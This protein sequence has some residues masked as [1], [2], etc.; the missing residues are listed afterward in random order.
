[1]KGEIMRQAQWQLQTAKAQL[2][3]LIEAALRGNPQR[4]TRRGKDAVMVLSERAYVA[5]KSSAKKDAPDF[6]AHL[7]AMP[8]HKTG[9]SGEVALRTKLAL[10]DIDL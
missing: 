4:I 5:L 1:V 6:A 3:E 2:S 8:R 7:L 9:R 10:R